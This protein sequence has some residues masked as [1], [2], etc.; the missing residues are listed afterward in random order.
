MDYCRCRCQHRCGKHRCH[1]Y[2]E[3]TSVDYCRCRCCLCQH[4]C[5]K[6]RCHG[7]HD[8]TSVDYCRCRCCLCQHRCGKH[9]CHGYQVSFCEVVSPVWT[10][11]EVS[12][13]FVST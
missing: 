11:V 4:R 6:H 9:R 2:H 13:L 10:T 1:G 3:V 5:G 12:L 8:V 7:Y